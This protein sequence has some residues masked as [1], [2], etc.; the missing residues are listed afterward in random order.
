M[1]LPIET[2]PVLWGAAG[3]AIVLAVLGFSWG[4]WMTGSRAEMA[5]MMH[6][7]TAVVSALV[8]VCVE[9]FRRDPAAASNLEALRKAD[10]WSQ[11]EFIEKGGW[12]NVIAAA[13]SVQLTSVARGCAEVLVKG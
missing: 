3:G 10:S 1:K 9:K 6:A 8:P 11:G 4:G 12:A 5:A 13:G 7:D 2:K